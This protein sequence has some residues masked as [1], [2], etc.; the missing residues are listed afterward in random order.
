MRWLSLLLAAFLLAP[1]SGAV[2][3]ATQEPE[4]RQASE[5]HILLRPFAFEPREIRLP[6]GEPVRL[7]FVNSGQATLSF[8]A[9]GFFAAS[10]VRS[11]DADLVRGGTIR[12]AP[13]ER[14]SV[15]LVARAGRYHLR[16]GNFLHRLLGMAGR[17]IVE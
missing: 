9:G 2:A 3:A 1:L 17:I 6:A 14:R 13:G 8:T 16:S 5:H 15:L 10:R 11:G 4:W 7:Y 12:L